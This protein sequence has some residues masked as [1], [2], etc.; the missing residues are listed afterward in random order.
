MDQQ[1]FLEIIWR[2]E[3]KTL[4]LEG[5]PVLTLA[6]S[7][8]QLPRGGPGGRRIGRYYQRVAEAWRGRWGRE[9]Y[10]PACLDLVRCREQAQIFQPWQASLEGEIRYQDSEILSVCMDAREVRGDG[11]PLLVRTGDLWR[12]PQ[13]V[14][15]PVGDYVSGARRWWPRLCRLLAQ[16]GEARRAAGDC[17]LDQ[18]FARRLPRALSPRRC[19]RTPE[20]L[21]FYAPQASLAPAVEGTP[22]F[23]VTLEE[24]SDLCQKQKK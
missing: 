16:Q 11:R 3:E 12:L 24:I 5:E 19:C 22:V 9:L 14:P 17:F 20:G 13:G 4:T 10:W 6:L 15:L 23:T 8:P 2:R 7:W 18:D 1:N 21:E